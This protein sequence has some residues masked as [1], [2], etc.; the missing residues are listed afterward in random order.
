MLVVD[1]FQISYFSKQDADHLLN[2]LEDRYTI[3]TDWYGEKYID[4]DFKQDY[5]ED[6]FIL[7]MKGLVER[8]L[9]ELNFIRTKTKPTQGPTLYTSPEYGKKIQYAIQDLSLDLDPEAINNIQ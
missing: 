7:S 8:A 1:D 4:I 5:I 2:A 3:K 6:E 9:K